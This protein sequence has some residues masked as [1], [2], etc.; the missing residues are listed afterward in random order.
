MGRPKKGHHGK[1]HGKKGHHGAHEPLPNLALAAIDAV[2]LLDEQD[3][4]EHHWLGP[5]AAPRDPT[6]VVAQPA[7]PLRNKT[8]VTYRQLIKSMTDA[9]RTAASGPPRGNPTRPPPPPPQVENYRVLESGEY[10]CAPR[11]EEPEEPAEQPEAPPKEDALLRG[12]RAIRRASPRKSNAR[13]TN[14]LGGV[15][16][17]VLGGVAEKPDALSSRLSRARSPRATRATLTRKSKG[18]MASAGVLR[19]TSTMADVHKATADFVRRHSRAPGGEHL[20]SAFRADEAFRAPP[21]PAVEEDAAPDASRE[22][23]TGLA[24]AAAFQNTF[25]GLKKHLVGKLAQ[26]GHAVD[27]KALAT[28]GAGNGRDTFKGASLGRVPLVS[29]GFW[30]SDHPSE[31]SRRVDVLLFGTRTRAGLRVEATNRRW[32]RCSTSSCT[33]PR[34]S[35]CATC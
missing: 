29:A 20:A 25:N 23:A 12:T 26:G 35:A 31:R 21:P 11:P 3:E 24:R 16:A 2:K 13:K 15:A 9:V 17:A 18:A 32:A 27:I 30:T 10:T 14:A 34:R 28:G 22:E 8:Q 4:R 19:I 7:R 33:R 6:K 5:A 1:G